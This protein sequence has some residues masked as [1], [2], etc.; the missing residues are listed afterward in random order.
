MLSTCAQGL[1]SLPHGLASSTVE[2]HF[3]V[4]PVFLHHTL[5]YANACGARTGRELRNGTRNAVL[6]TAGQKVQVKAVSA[7]SGSFFR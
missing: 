7:N 6:G 2:G 5:A 3:C 4:K 1:S